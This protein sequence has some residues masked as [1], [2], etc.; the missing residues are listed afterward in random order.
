MGNAQRI[1]LN[2]GRQ[3]FRLY[4]AELLTLPCFSSLPCR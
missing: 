3:S 4:N 2:P 1:L